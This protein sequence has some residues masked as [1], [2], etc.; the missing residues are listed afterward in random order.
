MRTFNVI[1]GSR[2]FFDDC[3]KDVENNAD[4]FID[5]VKLSD[6]LRNTRRPFDED[7]KAEILIIKNDSYNG[8]T[9]AANDR[10]GA[11]IYEL[12]LEDAVIW[13]HNPPSNLLRYLN[14]QESMRQIDIRFIRQEYD[15]ERDKNKYVKAIESIQRKI[16][17]QNQ[18][19]IEIS[20]TLNYL[21]S[22]K[23]KKPYVIMLFGNSSIGKTELVREIAKNFFNDKFFEKHL[24][25][26][27]NTANYDY[28]FG[29]KPNRRTLAFELLERESNLIFLDEIDKCADIFHSVFYTLFDNTVFMD[30]SYEVDISGILVIL[31]SNYSDEE[32]IKEKLGLPIFYRIDK[33]IHF[34]D[35]SSETIYSIVRKEIDDRYEE[36]KEFLTKDEIY[37][38]ISKQI[39]TTG[40]NARTIKYKIQ[41]AIEE[42][43]FVKLFTDDKSNLG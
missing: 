24:S 34:Y 16:I 37:Q 2:N 30:S 23:R 7:D 32:E 13:V 10:I 28:L 39:M 18:A 40:E 42:L 4:Y 11:L 8:I 29:D 14:S 26:F 33:F 25:M 20:K 41:T 6:N 15:L 12:T 9:E 19:V 27:R 17:G 3:V 43:L 38:K 1:I 36:Y 22:V 21:T 35:F 5:L 31:T